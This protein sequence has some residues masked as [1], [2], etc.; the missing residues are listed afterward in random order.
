MAPILDATVIAVSIQVRPEDV[1]MIRDVFDRVY[2]DAAYTL[3][4]KAG[5]D[6]GAMLSSMH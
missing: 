4:A 6:P 2:R 1:P 5:G 3:R